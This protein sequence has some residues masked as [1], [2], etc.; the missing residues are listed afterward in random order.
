[1]FGQVGCLAGRTIA[2]R[3][4]AFVPAVEQ[5]VRQ[6]VL[7]VPQHVGD[8]RVLTNELLRNGWRTVY[9]STA[10]VE[11]EAPSDW[12]TFWRQQLRWGRSS[13]RETLLSLRWLWRRPVAF[14]CFASDIV[15][16]F[17]LY[18]VVVFAVARAARGDAGPAGLPLAMELPLAYA[19]MLVSIGLR[20]IPR[21]RRAPRDLRRLP[22]F[23]LQVT[24][25][26]VPVRIAAFATMFNQGWITRSGPPVHVA[27]RSS[28]RR[29]E[30]PPEPA[31]AVHGEPGA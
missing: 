15:T 9:Q 10:R 6:T 29:P 8:D 22:L 28:M 25:V 17:A 5:L 27:L 3:R 20:Q 23:V 13:Q 1:V 26:M 11:T 16:P 12:P 14:L 30:L 2:Y 19:G 21:F 7:G 31:M 24:F 4:T 18:A